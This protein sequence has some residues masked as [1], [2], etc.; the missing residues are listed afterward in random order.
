M[1]GFFFARLQVPRLAPVTPQRL[2][3]LAAFLQGLGLD[4]SEPGGPGPMASALAPIG[5]A[6]SHSS[7][8]EQ[9]N[10]EHLEFLGDAVLRLA[11]TEFLLSL[12]HI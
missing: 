11:A 10:H 6:L 2:A 8:G 1:P 12:I 7:L 3:Q 5:E 4:P 9:L